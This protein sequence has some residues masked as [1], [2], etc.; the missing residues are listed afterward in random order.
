[1]EG[2]SYS[3]SKDLFSLSF[4]NDTNERHDRWKDRNKW[5]HY[6]I[7][8]RVLNFMKERGFEIGRDPK[9]MKYY[10]CLNKDH[11]YGKKK[12][13]EFKADRYP[14]GWKIEFYQNINVENS[15]GGEYDFDKF[16][17]APYLIKLL[18][19][20]ETNHIARFI[21]HIVPDVICNSDKDYK[22]AEDKIKKNFQSHF[23]NE[24]TMDFDLSK[25]DGL[26]GDSQY[27]RNKKYTYNCKDK[28][29]HILV[30][31]TIKYF[32]DGWSGRLQRG[33]IYHNINN[34]W[35][36]IL[37]DT[38]YDNVA[39]F[40]LFEP[41][42]EDFKIRRLKKGKK[43]KEYLDKLENLKNLS[44]KELLREIKKRGIKVR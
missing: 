3:I 29:G 37:N 43:P 34:M 11:W 25:L 27:R 7:L 15:N 23:D 32:R 13:L 44:N 26:E 24:I 30:N 39:D 31:G 21:E 12:G 20:N 1:M 41:K 10:K 5:S 35:W 6:P 38:E 33:K 22:L 42:E 28:D 2:Y 18:W 36:V 40:E 4:I 8:H 17:K 19:I 9:I 16:D 14:R